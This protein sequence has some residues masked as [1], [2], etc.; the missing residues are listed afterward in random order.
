MGGQNQMIQ[1][2]ESVLISIGLIMQLTTEN[3]PQ[4]SQAH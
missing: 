4:N 1:T 3:Q 2:L